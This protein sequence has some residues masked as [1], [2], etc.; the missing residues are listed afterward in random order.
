MGFN[1]YTFNIVLRIIVLTLTVFL[2]AVIAWVFFRAETFGQA[3]VVLGIMFDLS[4]INYVA[5]DKL[6]D[7]NAVNVLL[8]I[9]GLQLFFHF[10]L[11]KA[12]WATSTSRLKSALEQ[13][14]LAVLIL[15][16]VFMRGPG[17]KFIYFQF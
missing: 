8:L 16:C 10:R 9:I 15:T 5:A 12:P 13:V 4:N 6:I 3:I 7:N 2:L 1:N 17:S 11:D 14:C